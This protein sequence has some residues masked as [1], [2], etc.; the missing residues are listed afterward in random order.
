MGCEIQKNNYID[1]NST[2]QQENDIRNWE[3]NLGTFNQNIMDIITKIN[4]KLLFD[5][6]N[7]PRENIIHYFNLEVKENLFKSILS[8]DIFRIGSNKDAEFDPEMIKILFFILTKSNQSKSKSNS[9]QDKAK[10]LYS[11]LKDEN[12]DLD[13]VIEKENPTLAELM[14]TCVYISTEVLIGIR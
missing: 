5:S 1:N 11:F 6:H 13:S 2:C 10:I 9:Y 8:N 14:E 3:M 7:I 4:A 12:E